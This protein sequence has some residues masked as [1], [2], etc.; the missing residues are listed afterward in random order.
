M[1]RSKSLLVLV[2][3]LATT[4]GQVLAACAPQDLAAPQTPAAPQDPARAQDPARRTPTADTPS[5]AAAPQ[6]ETPRERVLVTA[7]KIEEPLIDVPQAVSS[8]DAGDIRDRGADTVRDLSRYV[9][10]VLLTEFTSRRLSLPYIRGV[11]SGQGDP[12]VTTFIDG[13]PQL[14][15]SSANLPLFDAE[16]VE[17]LRGP[18]SA[19]YGRNTL[20][21]AISITSAPPVDELTGRARLTLGNFERRDFEASVSAPIV[22]DTLSASFA[23]RHAEREGYTINDLNGADVDSRDSNFGRA[24]FA[25]TPTES[26]TIRLSIHGEAARDGGFALA[27]LQSQRANPNRL[28]QDFDG[29]VDRDL[30]AATLNWQHVADDFEFQSITGVQ[31]WEIAETADFDFSPIDG[32]RRFTDEEQVY[33]YQEFR[34]GSPAEESIRVGDGLELGWLAGVS[35]FWSDTEQ[36]AVNE[37]RP[38]GAGILFPP[39][40]VGSDRAVGAFDALALGVYGQLTLTVHERLEL[41]AALRYD[42]ESRDADIRRTFVAGGFEIPVASTDG[43]QDFDELLPRFS[44]AYEVAEPAR[45]YALASRGFKAGGF[46]LT[47]PTGLESFGTETSWTY[48]IGV[49]TAWLDDTLTASFAA[50]WI[51]WDDMQLSQ[52]DPAAGG[53]VTNAGE[54]ES[55]GIEIEAAWEMVEGLQ[56]VGAFG[57]LETEFDTFIDSFGQN[58]RGNQLPFA[59]E[60]TASLG[61]QYTH[62][63]ADGDWFAFARV[64]FFGVGRFYYDAGNLASEQYELV[65]LRAGAGGRHWE[66]VG[67]VNNVGDERYQAVALQGNPADPTFFVAE[68]AAPLNFGFAGELRF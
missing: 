68:S 14:T 53:Y 22:T 31:G 5:D 60:T 28:T 11:G 2:A 63:F 62:E 58:V 65:N 59:P 66:F 12:A 20:G 25:W 16:R 29:K 38:G 19:L 45:V 47:A 56:L 67:F 55:R 32:V 30:A 49:K 51:D 33:V 64:D 3:V 10:N 21:G 9:P 35:G 8:F 4:S 46:N 13:V 23:F 15:V 26:D 18:S 42:Y 43:G 40:N 57:F 39:T 34:I 41:A 17:F 50:F 61:L 48:E 1:P 27:P 24:Q 37:F 44:I 36:S 7:R 6:D 52:F 54:S